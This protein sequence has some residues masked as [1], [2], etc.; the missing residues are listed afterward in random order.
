MTRTEEKLLL[1]S[2]GKSD[3]RAFAVLYNMY[4]GKCLAFVQSLIKDGDAAKDITHDIF[5]KVWLKRDV[6]SKVDNFSSYLFRMAHNAVMDKLDTEVIK[7]RFMTEQMIISD[8]FRSYVD[9]RVS[10]E[11]LQILIFKALSNMPE[12]RRKIFTLSRY[13]GM[14]NSEIAQIFNIS[15][16]TVENHITNA[17]TD[18][19]MILA[20]F[21]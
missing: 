21:A 18:I 7:R 10:V 11:E 12:Q 19:R 1:N 5:V 6:I 20:E 9:E 14:S 17:L 13:K 16:R 4:A 3:K 2:L 15:V 8:N